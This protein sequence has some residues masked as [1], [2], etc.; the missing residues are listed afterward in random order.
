MTYRLTFKPN[1]SVYVF[2]GSNEYIDVTDGVIVIEPNHDY[3]LPGSLT[4]TGEEMN[5]IISFSVQLYLLNDNE[6]IIL[7]SQSQGTDTDTGYLSFP[8]DLIKSLYYGSDYGK[9]LFIDFENS[10]YL[11]LTAIK[12]DG[13]EFNTQLNL[14]VQSLKDL[15]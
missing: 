14:T 4:Y 7:A 1:T 9:D 3:V 15:F 5:D 6:K 10:L 2:H 11:S 13:S 12:K 8:D